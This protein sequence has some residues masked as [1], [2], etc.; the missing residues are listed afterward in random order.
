MSARKK[1]V[2]THN[3]MKNPKNDGYYMAIVTRNRK[4]L[5]VDMVSFEDDHSEEVGEGK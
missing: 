3:T 1:G 2:L 5:V 4:T